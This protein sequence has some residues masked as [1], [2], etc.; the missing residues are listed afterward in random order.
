M[1]LV[2]ICATSEASCPELS[3]HAGLP[4]TD[5]PW[6]VTIRRGLGYPFNV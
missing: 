2:I 1:R 6:V 3:V 4:H 5:L